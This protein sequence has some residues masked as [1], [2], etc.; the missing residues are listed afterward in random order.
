[1]R[2]P[3][4]EPTRLLAGVHWRGEAIATV[5]RA[6]RR[7]CTRHAWSP[8]ARRSRERNEPSLPSL[9][10][11]ESGKGHGE[12]KSRAMGGIGDEA[13]ERRGRGVGGRRGWLVGIM[14]K[15]VDVGAHI[16]AVCSCP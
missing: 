1:M 14:E 8:G 11:V 6:E 5:D 12:R 9:Q 2:G 7:R 4:Q 10:K 16:F 3:L 15:V 13:C